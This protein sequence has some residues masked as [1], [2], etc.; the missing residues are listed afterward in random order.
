MRTRFVALIAAVS[1]AV[2]AIFYVALGAGAAT[3][4]ASGLALPGGLALTAGRSQAASPFAAS[5]VAPTATAPVAGPGIQVV[6]RGVVHAKP[7]MAWLNV[8]VQTR[9]QT[10]QEAQNQNNQQMANVIAALKGKGIAEQDIQTMGVSLNPVYEREQTV[11]GYIAT[12]NVRVRVANIAAVG[13][14]LDAAIAA[15]ANQ[16]GGVQFG[17]TNETTLYQQ[18]MAEATKDA[19][20]KADALAQALG[21]TVTGIEAVVEEVGGGPVVPMDAVGRAAASTPIEPGELS[22]RAQVRVVY[23]YQ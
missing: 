4:G 3:R 20:A 21:V 11:T 9:A 2:V 14:L 23:S 1:I 10:A 17:L 15:G 5:E 18:A 16:A 22:V 7:D 19:R 6:G 13:D 12:N 8:G